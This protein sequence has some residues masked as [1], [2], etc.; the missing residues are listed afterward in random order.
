MLIVVLVISLVSLFAGLEKFALENGFYGSMRT[1][2]KD[3]INIT[4]LMA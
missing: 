2:A 3:D 1:S 4:P